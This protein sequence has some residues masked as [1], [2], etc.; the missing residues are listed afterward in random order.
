MAL[1]LVVVALSLTGEPSTVHA[2]NTEAPAGDELSKHVSATEPVY[3][4]EDDTVTVEL[5][6]PPAFTA[7]GVVAVSEKC[8]CWTVTVV[9]PVA[10]AY[11][12]SPL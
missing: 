10:G 6:E 8:N 11:T 3:P 7:A 12:E 4:S 2:G 5:V 9:V 1:P